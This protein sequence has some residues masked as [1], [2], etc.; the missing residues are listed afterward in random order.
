M[1]PAICS[2]RKVCA[3]N[4]DRLLTQIP[5]MQVLEIPE[6]PLC[7]GSAGI[8]NLVQPRRRRNW[9]IAKRD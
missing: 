9:G 8:Y 2:M 6:S 1:I 4:Q 3:P 7:C 5:D